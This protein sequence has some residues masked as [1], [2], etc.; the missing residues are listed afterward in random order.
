MSIH[1]KSRG[2]NKIKGNTKEQRCQNVQKENRN[3]CIL[4][5]G[6]QNSERSKFFPYFDT[7]KTLFELLLELRIIIFRVTNSNYN[8]AQYLHLQNWYFRTVATFRTSRNENIPTSKAGNALMI[9]QDANIHRPA[10]LSGDPSAYFLPTS[11]ST[12][13][14]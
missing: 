2:G 9:L 13:I 10:L 4:T 7:E 11:I 5:K 1:A 8:Y 14:L 3:T 6:R 12:L